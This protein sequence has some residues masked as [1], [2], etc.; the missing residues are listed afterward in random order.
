MPPGDSR[1]RAPPAGTTDW[2]DLFRS[3]GAAG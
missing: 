1:C 3:C 2:P